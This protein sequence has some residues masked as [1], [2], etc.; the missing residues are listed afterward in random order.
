MLCGEHPFVLVWVAEEEWGACAHRFRWHW[1]HKQQLCLIC[2]LICSCCRAGVTVTSTAQEPRD[3]VC[4]VSPILCENP[5]LASA[6]LCLIS[7]QFSHLLKP[8]GLRAFPEV[9]VLCL[10]CHGCACRNLLVLP[11]CYTAPC[12]P[13]L[14]CCIAKRLKHLPAY[15]LALRKGNIW[16]RV[17]L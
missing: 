17:I 9:V 1:L 5:Y 14:Q 13:R 6:S 16:G 12:M 3:K 10:L 11:P 2:S 4:Q 7:H 15:P 8:A